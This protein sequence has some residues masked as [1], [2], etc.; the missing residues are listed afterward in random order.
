MSCDPTILV[1]DARCI[2]CGIPPGMQMPVLISLF[3]EILANGGGG[4][5]PSGPQAAN[6]V[7]AGPETGAPAAPTFRALVS[8][9]IPQ[10]LTIQTLLAQESLSVGPNA[11]TIGDT[12][13]IL[14]V[15]KA[16]EGDIANGIYFDC[17]E[18]NVGTRLFAS[19]KIRLRNS[20]LD[21]MRLRIPFSFPTG[22]QS[23]LDAREMEQ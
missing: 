7:F 17:D 14:N 20:I 18:F 6:M 8:E 23:C 13:F 16:G 5:L 1:A 10:T 2:E 3:C 21:M 9:D 22:L 19:P 15:G 4:D 12:L 11:N